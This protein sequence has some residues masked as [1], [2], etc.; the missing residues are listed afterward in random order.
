[1]LRQCITFLR[2]RGYSSYLPLDQHIYLHKLTGMMV[3]V[4]S[5]V[6][7]LMHL[8]NFSTVVV[9]NEE[10]NKGN[11]T[12]AEWIFTAKPGLFGLVGGWANPTGVILFVII[13]IMFVCS[14]AFVRRG[15][16]FEVSQNVQKIAQ[17]QFLYFRFFIGPTCCIYHFGFC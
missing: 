16:C 14:Q 11:F 4:Y 5:V 6:H 12:T 9:Y 8:L 17:S 3:F 7:T 15:G 10:I 1:M 2:T 13:C